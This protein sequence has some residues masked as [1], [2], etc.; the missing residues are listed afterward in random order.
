MIDRRRPV[1]LFLFVVSTLAV[2][3]PEAGDVRYGVSESGGSLSYQGD[4]NRVSVGVDDDGDFYGEFLHVFGESAGSNWIGEGWFGQQGRGGVKLNYHWLPG[5]W[6]TEDLLD[7]DDVPG[8]RKLFLAADQNAFDDRKVSLGFGYERE[9]TFLAGYLTHAISGNRRLGSATTVF[10]D[11]I[12]GVQDGRPFVQDRTI[13]TLT[14]FFAHPYDYGLGLRIGRF[15]DRPLLRVRG[16]LDIEKG[17]FGS[18]QTTLTVGLEKFFHGSGHSLR[19][20]IEH[21][22]KDG[23]F[24]ID[25]SDTRAF[26]FW[27]Y[28]FGNRSNFAPAVDYRET[29]VTS[30]ALDRVAPSPAPNPQ[31]V[32]NRITAE[33]SVLFDFDRSEL[34]PPALAELRELVAE[35]RELDIVGPIE[36]T[37]HTCDIGTETY[38][39]GLSERRASS[40]RDFLV[41]SGISPDDIDVR[42]AGESEPRYPNDGEENRRRNRRTEIEFVTVEENVAVAP[43][44][45]PEPTQRITWEREPINDPAWVKRALRNPVQHKRTVDYYRFQTETTTETLGPVVFLNSAPVAVDDS[46][47]ISQNSSGNV[48]D[49]LA[50]DS[51]VDQDNLIIESVSGAANGIVTISGD[52]LLYT[53]NAGFVGVDTFTYVISDG[54]ENASATVTV[55]VFNGPPIAVDDALVAARG[56]VNRLDVLANDT[57]PDG[58]ELSIVAVT[59]P[60]SG[61]AFIDGDRVG[62]TAPDGFMGTDTFM[63]TVADGNSNEST[64]TVTVTVDN[65]APVAVDDEGST[66]KN[67]AVVVDVLANDFDPNGDELTVISAGPQDTGFG[68]VEVLA[69]NRILYTPHPDWWGGDVFQYTISD[70]LGGTDTATV[71]LTISEFE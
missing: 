29:A 37:G 34:L 63:Y 38:N 27:R 68:T 16:G 23:D 31:L 36:V 4:T 6:T 11:Q 42:A 69:D 46:Y 66:S 51:D 71:T 26:L 61:S 57:D 43:R 53:P 48:L 50:N 35:I 44:P 67:T 60:M 41:R 45:A 10:T 13:E 30:P 39:Q 49:V 58:D 33:D 9:H 59:N 18:D 70:G 56:Q 21:A 22:E 65:D 55:E 62:Y 28:Q 12:E 54:E 8:I 3:Q 14:E 5:D 20:D 7:R 64:A 25:D 17:D 24:E 15:L 32:Q 52:R 1:A 19:L 47:V 40:V 2:A